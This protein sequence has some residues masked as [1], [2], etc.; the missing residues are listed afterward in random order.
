L[1]HADEVATLGDAELVARSRDGEDESYAELFRRHQ[2]AALGLARTLTDHSAADDIVAEAFEK[3]LLRIRGGGGPESAFRPYLMQ[4]VRTVAVDASRRTS[5]LVVADEPEAGQPAGPPEDSL[6]DTV[7]ERTTLARAFGALPE[8]WQTFL[9]MSFVEGAD[10][11]EIATVLGINPGGVSALGY[12]AREGLRRAYL[13]A[14]LVDA[15]TDECSQVWPLL[16]GA[17]RGGLSPAQRQRV[18]EHVGECDYCRAALIELDAVNTRLGALIAPLVLGAAAPAYLAAVGYAPG[19]AAGSAGSSAA[20][21]AAGGSASPAGGASLEATGTS[22]AAKTSL[23]GL[24]K[25]SATGAALLAGTSMLAVVG[26]IAVFTAPLGSERADVPVPGLATSDGTDGSADGRA[27]D[28]TGTSGDA[29]TGP[30]ETTSGGATT[31]LTD[32]PT[33][34]TTGIPT[35]VPTG[36]GAPTVTSLPTGTATPTGTPT[37]GATT[38]PTTGPSGTRS[39][40]PTQAPTSVSTTSPTGTG[41]PSPTS[42]PTEEVDARLGNVDV[43]ALNG[44]GPPIHVGIPVTLSGGTADLV[45][46]VSVVGL[47]NYQNASAG[48]WSCT[49]IT[50]MGGNAKTATVRCRLAAASPADPLTLGLDIAYVGDA[51]LTAQLTVEAPAVDVSG[52]DST[53]T[54]LPPI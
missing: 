17:V 41:N 44:P 32:S 47:T 36:T 2:P 28:G 16:S 20:T 43:T 49:A 29:S 26:L 50:P 46:D 38:S 9:W 37:A 27:P 1:D 3:L 42:Q 15:P 10:R 8:R 48:N 30:G 21:D 40:T 53:S 23:A 34:S 11:G 24:L 12:R 52:D 33:A 25:F 14:H 45:V 22:A 5:R 51:S 13:D 19:A 31:S 54:D 39:P 4:T 35:G 7:Y 6:F 18:D